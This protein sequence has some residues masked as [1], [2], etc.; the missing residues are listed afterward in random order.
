MPRIITRS[1]TLREELRRRRPR[2]LLHQP[3]SVD[4]VPPL[5]DLPV[6]NA[7]ERHRREP[8]APIR[9]RHAEL[10]AAVRPLARE[11]HGALLPISHDVVDRDA[12]V[13]KRAD[14]LL[15]KWPEPR[16]PWQVTA[17]L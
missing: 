9:R 15:V 5:H 17:I 13:G 11:P 1:R 6:A 2:Q 10:P 14:E 7:H 3:D 8:H 12:D 16:R 4:L